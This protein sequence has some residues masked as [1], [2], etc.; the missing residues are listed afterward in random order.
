[1]ATFQTFEHPYLIKECHLDTFGHVN[2]ATYLQIF[3]E[4]RWEIISSLGFG[5]KT[6]LKNGQGP[7]ILNINIRFHLELRNR[8]QVTIRSSVSKYES[9]IGIMKQEIFNTDDKL[10]CSAELT[11]GLFDVRQRALISPT[12][13]WLAAVGCTP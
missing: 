12:P 7:T 2:N 11:F 9:K 1:M 3:E 4:I 10:A 13:E 5:Y 8:E 6:I